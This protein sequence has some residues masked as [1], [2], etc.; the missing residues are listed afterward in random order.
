MTP[1]F[2]VQQHVVGNV[3]SEIMP[4]EVS[5][6]L[7][8]KMDTVAWDLMHV[9]VPTSSQLEDHV[10]EFKLVRKLQLME[11]TLEISLV[12]YHEMWM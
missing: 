7:F 1:Q 3:V 5:S 2:R 9:R 8:A 4:V 6:A 10:M 11:G 12:S